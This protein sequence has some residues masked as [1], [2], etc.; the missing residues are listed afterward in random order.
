MTFLSPRLECGMAKGKNY[1]L[2]GF[3][4]ARMEFRRMVCW[5]KREYDCVERSKNDVFASRVSWYLEAEISCFC[6][7]HMMG[8]RMGTEGREAERKR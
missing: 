1:N 6:D 7:Q 4:I 3:L 8:E 5:P 2:G